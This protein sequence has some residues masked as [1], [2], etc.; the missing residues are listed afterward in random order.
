MAGQ[1]QNESLPGEVSEKLEAPS[2][3][4]FLKGDAPTYNDITRC[5]HCGLCLSVCPTYKETG[6]ETESPRGRLYLMRAFAQGEIS[7]SATLASHLDLCLQCRACE[8]VCPSGVKYGHLVELTLDEV[9]QQRQSHQT[10]I[11]KVLRWLIFRQLFPKPRNLRLFALAMRFYQRTPLQSLTRKLKLLHLPLFKWSGL[12]RMAVLEETM[13]PPV[14]KPLFDPPATGKVPALIEQKYRVA[15]FGGCIMSMAFARVND[16]TIRVLRRNYCEVV[17]PQS[18][19]CC[20]ALHAHNGD[21]DYSK[22]MA[23]QNIEVFEEAERVHGKFDAIIINA[24]GCGAMLKEY[25]ELLKHDPDYAERAE[26]FAHRVKDLS[27]FVAGLDFN[28]EFGRVEKRIT[29]QDSCHLAHGQK[30][31]LQPRTLLKA[32]PGLELVEMPESDKCCGSAGVYNVTQY[33]MSMQILDHKLENAAM[34][35]PDYIITAN[36]GCQLQMQLGVRRAG[37]TN[38]NGKAVEVKHYVE[39]L[40]E[41]YRAAET[42]V[43][44]GGENK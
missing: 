31:R 35:K 19:N 25:G 34:V 28:R 15:L 20:G 33:D 13:L 42:K 44:A 9:S 40:D 18:L 2:L 14:S 17:I 3:V 36:P 29:Y 4:G 8:T 12:E 16:A 39:I 10:T 22:Q 23:R 24:G 32:I 5:I 1:L 30:V 26:Q 21:R 38:A 43:Q 37:L 6:L 7:A 11:E 41:A 27:E